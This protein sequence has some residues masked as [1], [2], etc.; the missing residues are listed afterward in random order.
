MIDT[1]GMD[2]INTQAIRELTTEVTGVK[3]KIKKESDRIDSLTADMC[4]T[5]I[6][7]VT[8]PAG[9]T[10]VLSAG[11]VSNFRSVTV[12]PIDNFIP[13]AATIGLIRKGSVWITEVIPV[14]CF[15][16][17]ESK[18]SYALR[19]VTETE[20]EIDQLKFAITYK[21]S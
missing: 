14:I 11:Q 21:H 13:V 9:S 16:N 1:Y 20:V 5:K 6:Q 18:I 10:I 4:I 17:S 8:L 2:D 7:D 12:T 19:N 15:I 3:Q